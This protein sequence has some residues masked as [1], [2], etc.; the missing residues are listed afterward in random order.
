MA[1]QG[2]NA[3]ASP[4]EGSRNV[5]PTRATGAESATGA[6]IAHET[7]Q[8]SPPKGAE[9]GS[10]VE[11]EGGDPTP[12]L[13]GPQTP[14][15]LQAE[16]AMFVSNGSISA[17]D[18]PSPTGLQPVSN[19]ATSVEHARELVKTKKDEHAAFVNRSVK[20]K[21]LDEDEVAR[22]GRA[23]L[24]AIG[25]QRGYDMPEAGTRA[26]RA[27]FLAGQDADKG[28]GGGDVGKRR[29]GAPVSDANKSAKGSQQAR[30]A[31]GTKASLSK[32]TKRSAPKGGA[33]KGGRGK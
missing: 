12:D 4:K 18:I 27:A 30:G 14:R 33:T 29:G 20:A 21:R 10:Q 8:Q 17:T 15:G 11:I 6:Q 3:N 26:T 28:L 23:E 1:P 22:M 9:A 32:A 24:N 5:P 19:V 2:E 13:K 16:T 31:Q 7:G 25:V